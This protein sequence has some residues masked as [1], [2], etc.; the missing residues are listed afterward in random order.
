MSYKKEKKAFPAESF[1]I[2]RGDS[3]MDLLDYFAAKAMQG[4]ISQSS[5]LDVHRCL[6]ES[7]ESVTLTTELTKASYKVA[8]EMI[9][10]R[11]NYYNS[12]R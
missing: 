5:G 11:E 4:F 6:K 1:P 2:D 12:K 10:A 8:N 9:E 3:G 7:E